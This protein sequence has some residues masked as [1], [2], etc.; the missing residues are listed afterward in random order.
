VTTPP[1]P[2]IVHVVSLAANPLPLTV[3]TVPSGPELGVREIGKPAKLNVAEPESRVLPISTT[4]YVPGGWPPATVNDAEIT[5]P[6]DMLHEAAEI[7][8]VL[9]ENEPELQ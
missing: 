3:T 7:L 6:S 9:V 5:C 8:S 1:V 4:V 2:E